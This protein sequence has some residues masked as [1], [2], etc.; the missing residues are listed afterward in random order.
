MVVSNWI[1]QTFQHDY[2]TFAEWLCSALPYHIMESSLII[3][4]TDSDD[5]FSDN[6][7]V[8]DSDMS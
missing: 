5:E 8:L 1:T 2:E 7:D 6:S 3:S 4:G